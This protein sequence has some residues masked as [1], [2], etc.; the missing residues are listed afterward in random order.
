MFPQ[1]NRVVSIW[2]DEE[3]HGERCLPVLI[4][5]H[6]TKFSPCLA[7]WNIP[8]LPL[9]LS[10]TRRLD[11]RARCA[12]T[13]LGHEQSLF[14]ASLYP[15][16]RTE[17][18]GSIAMGHEFQLRGNTIHWVARESS[19]GRDGNRCEVKGSSQK[20]SGSILSSVDQVRWESSPRSG[21]RF[22]SKAICISFFTEHCGRGKRLW[23][24]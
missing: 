22:A 13:I 17:A 14:R 21:F 8:H 18:S 1:A 5:W 15:F 19:S 4:R 11:Q 9:F 12:L 10:K 24:K 2:S 6:L 3:G 23:T 16:P 7:R 20:R